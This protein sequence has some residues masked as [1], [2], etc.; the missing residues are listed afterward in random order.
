MLYHVTYD[1]YTN[2]INRTGLVPQIGRVSRLAGETVPAVHLF[3]TFTDAAHAAE[4]RKKPYGEDVVIL[5]I[6]ENHIPPN[7]NVLDKTVKVFEVIP[8]HAIEFMEAV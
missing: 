7:M 8:S 5:T 4:Y 3:K 2:S 6:N 1:K